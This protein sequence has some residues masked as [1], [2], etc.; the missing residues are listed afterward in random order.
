MFIQLQQA[1]TIRLTKTHR[2]PDVYFENEVEPILQNEV[3]KIVPE[4]GEVTFRR[5]F[6]AR[7]TANF[8]FQSFPF[9]SQWL[10]VMLTP[11][12]F[13]TDQLQIYFQADPVFPEP[14]NTNFAHA[15]W[16][17]VAFKTERVIFQSR[18]GQPF[19]DRLILSIQVD[20]RSDSY[21]IKTVLPLILLVSLSC[22][23]YW[24]SVEAVPERLGLVGALNSML[25][26]FDKN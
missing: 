16:E 17:Y 10:P 22:I 6:L 14:N 18:A 7:L 5:H 24:F 11:Y 21:I 3:V 25:S 19:Y 2:T 12:S 1:R 4:T 26:H 20:R 9:D 8:E 13:N 15:A 23:S